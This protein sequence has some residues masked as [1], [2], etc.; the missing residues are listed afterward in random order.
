MVLV[1]ETRLALEQIAFPSH[2]NETRKGIKRL[3][4]ALRAKT[5]TKSATESQDALNAYLFARTL[6][7]VGADIVTKARRNGAS[8]RT[9]R[10]RLMTYAASRLNVRDQVPATFR[11]KA[12]VD[13][14]G[15][16]WLEETGMEAR[17]TRALIDYAFWIVAPEIKQS[18][19]WRYKTLN[20]A[21][22]GRTFRHRPPWEG[23]PRTT[24]YDSH[25][26][27][28]DRHKDR[29]KRRSK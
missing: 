25:C 15:G 2:T 11:Y 24:C 1:E 8:E 16:G 23:R 6:F 4:K 29:K 10:L 9:V 21:V 28:Q 13:A 17:D 18:M 12:V 26:R 19:W 7:E 3:R 5:A 22:C 27:K 14:N 20:C